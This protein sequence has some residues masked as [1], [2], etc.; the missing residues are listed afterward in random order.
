MPIKAELSADLEMPESEVTKQL[1]ECKQRLY[2]GGKV[3]GT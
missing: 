1:V 3:R 2:S